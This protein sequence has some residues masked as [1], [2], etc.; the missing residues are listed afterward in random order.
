ML[1]RGASRL[2]PASALLRTGGRALCTQPEKAPVAWW[3][4]SFDPDLPKPT[5]EE[6]GTASAHS[7]LVS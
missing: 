2:R 6:E 7:V 4:G 1:L 3:H 5:L